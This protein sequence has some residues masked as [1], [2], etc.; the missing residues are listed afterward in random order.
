MTYSY[1]LYKPSFQPKVNKLFYHR[2]AG[3]KVSDFLSGCRKIAE[4]LGEREGKIDQI[5][6][7]LLKPL[8]YDLRN[9]FDK[10]LFKTSVTSM[11]DLRVG[12]RLTGMLL[13]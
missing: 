3:T 10:P 1:F 7:S 5:I 2:M 12:Q 8:R 4:E 9:N 6:Q 13:L 11:S